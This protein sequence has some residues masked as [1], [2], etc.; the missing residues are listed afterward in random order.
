MPTVKKEPKINLLPQKEFEKSTLGRTLRWALS[1]FRIIVIMTEMFVMAAFLSRFWL[2]AK[3]S[4]LNELLL[5]K[6]GIIQSF[7]EVEREFRLAQKRIDIFS[8]M[9]AENPK[10]EY[11]KMIASFVPPDITLN[12]ISENQDLIQITGFSGSEQGVAQ[13]IVNLESAKEFKE[14]T[15]S[16]LDSDK[17]NQSLVTFTIKTTWH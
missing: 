14:V 9:T 16:S 17:E 12:S 2:D 5:Q 11:V 13:F 3:N 8:K 4:D 7:Q 10:P 15:L 6:K 1:S